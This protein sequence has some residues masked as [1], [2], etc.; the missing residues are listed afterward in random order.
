MS[1]SG[2]HDKRNIHL[3][4]LTLHFAYGKCDLI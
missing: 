3:S 4:D 1:P 2:N